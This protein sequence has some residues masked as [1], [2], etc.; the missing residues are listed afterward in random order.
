MVI[1]PKLTSITLVP[2][3]EPIDSY[4][5]VISPILTSVTREPQWQPKIGII[6]SFPQKHQ[7]L[8]QV[9]KMSKYPQNTLHVSQNDNE[10]NDETDGHRPTLFSSRRPDSS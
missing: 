4:Y 1:F 5:M 10:T 8:P 9:P 3:V 6:W 2:L 7:H